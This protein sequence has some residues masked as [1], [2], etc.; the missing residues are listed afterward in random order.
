MNKP[1]RLEKRDPITVHLTPA[2]ILAGVLL[3]VMMVSLSLGLNDNYNYLLGR[4]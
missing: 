1:V 3:I 4:I 2:I